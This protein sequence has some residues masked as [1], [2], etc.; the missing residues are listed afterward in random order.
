MDKKKKIGIAAILAVVLALGIGTFL[1]SRGSADREQEKLD[2]AVK[3]LIQNDY[4]KAILAFNEAIKIDP[5]EVKAYQGLARV[6]TLQGK[7]DEAKAAYD[8][9]LSAV[10]QDKQ[11]VLRLGLAG[12]YVDNN[13]LS[14]AEK[15]FQE[16]KNANKNGL[17]AYWGLA[18]VYQQQGDNA[19]AEA[20]L[21]QAVE[22]NPNEYRAYNTLALFLMQNRKPA[23][24]YN[25]LLKSL[26]LEI[27]QQE[28]YL[29]LSE[30]YKVPWGDMESKPEPASNQQVADMLEFHSYYT[31]EDYQ[32]VVSSYKTKVGQN[33]G[34]QKGKI[35]AAIAMIKTGDRSVAENLVKQ[36]LEEKLSDWLLSDL[37]R[38]YQIAG[39]NEKAKATAL[40]ALQA[41]A[42]DLEAI[43]LLQSLNTGQEKLYAAQYLLYNWKPVDKVKEELHTRSLPFVET[44]KESKPVQNNKPAE[45]SSALITPPKGLNED[46]QETY[47][48]VIKAY[49]KQED[50]IKKMGQPLQK[51]TFNSY[52]PVEVFIYNGLEIT[53][54]DGYVEGILSTSPQYVNWEGIRVGDSPSKIVEKY[55]Q[56]DINNPAVDKEHISYSNN[57]SLESYV[58]VNRVAF[59]GLTQ[60]LRFYIRNDQILGIKIFVV[61]GED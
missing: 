11:P 44:V 58:Q 33:A 15:A 45:Q 18:I 37:A 35:L 21:R 5:K 14:Q 20:I 12:M 32:E 50:V 2:L 7:Y 51:Q 30:L 24:A 47:L 41:N 39:D 27:N 4:E 31:S 22:Q 48:G 19:K 55:G 8:R 57:D 61:F 49:D 9:G 54:K 16:I 3:Y 10:E 56:L 36:L 52:S 59:Q 13:Q 42:T 34:N 40:K 53:F 43:A 17:E 23:A 29:I 38:Y 25:N 28:A 46:F 26:T 60:C 6:Y 1:W